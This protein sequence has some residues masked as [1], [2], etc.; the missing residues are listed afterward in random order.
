MFVTLVE[1]CCGSSQEG[2]YNFPDDIPARCSSLPR[3]DARRNTRRM[4]VERVARALHA[5]KPRRRLDRRRRESSSRTTRRRRRVEARRARRRGVDTARA[6]HGAPHGEDEIAAGLERLTLCQLYASRSRRVIRR[7]L[8]EFL[9]AGLRYVFPGRLGEVGC[10]MPTSILGSPTDVARP[11]AGERF[12]SRSAANLRASLRRAAA[13][14]TRLG[15]G[16]A[17]PGALVDDLSQKVLVI[18]SHPP[19]AYRGVPSPSLGQP[20]ACRPIPVLDSEHER[21][22]EEGL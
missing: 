2:A 13:S 1:S 3:P 21:A 22:R 17:S 18:C 8:A 7:N 15:K 12:P 16:R 4:E 6:R 14:Q 10:G 11:P 19:G 20:H 5:E 9:I